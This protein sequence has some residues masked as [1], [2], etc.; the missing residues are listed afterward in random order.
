MPKDKIEKLFNQ[1]RSDLKR[2]RFLFAL[3]IK[4]EIFRERI[5]LWKIDL[6]IPFTK[7]LVNF[8]QII[9]VK[10]NMLINWCI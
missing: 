4:V 1:E 3:G 10:L 8:K 6:W 2:L 7:L 5:D 9:N